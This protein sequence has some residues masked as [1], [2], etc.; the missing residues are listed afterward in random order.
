MSATEGQLD[1]ESS[2]GRFRTGVYA[3]SFD[4]AHNGHIDIARRAARLFDRLIVA[5]YELPAKN[6]LFSAAE[7]VELFRAGLAAAGAHHVVVEGYSGL[8]VHYARDRAACIVRGL[9]AFADFENEYQMSTMNRTL[10]P[11]VETIF[12]Q[13]TLE[14][15]HLSSTL[16]KEVAAGGAALDGL[17]PPP[18]ADALRMRLAGRRS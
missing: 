10:E 8:T 15:A 4:P 3:G 18:I 5:V 17:V 1:T 12:L 7:R 6:L 16:V 2:G 13:T 11:G 14:F 9:R